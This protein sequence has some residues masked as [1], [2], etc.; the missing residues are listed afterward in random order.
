MPRITRTPAIAATLALLVATLSAGLA[1]N[2]GPTTA[3]SASAAEAASQRYLV[4]YAAKASLADARAAIK[5]A[6]GTIV[7]ENRRIGL[8]TVTSSKSNFLAAVRSKAAL[9]GAARDIRIGRA[10]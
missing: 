2:A 10:P 7:R 5:A 3:G 1:P 4:L 9:V 6:G 8:A